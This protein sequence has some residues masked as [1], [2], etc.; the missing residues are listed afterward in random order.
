MKEWHEASIR[1]KVIR[2][3]KFKKVVS[4]TI[5]GIPVQWKNETSDLV[6]FEP[7]S[8]GLN[9]KNELKI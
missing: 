7:N 4:K 6:V 3:I 8:L 1:T 2:T 5:L 9:H